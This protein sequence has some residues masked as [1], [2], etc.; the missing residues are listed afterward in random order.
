MTQ[1]TF[2][3]AI[4]KYYLPLNGYFTIVSKTYM[5]IVSRW[6]LFT[7]L[8]GVGLMCQTCYPIQSQPT[9]SPT[10]FP[11]RELRGAWI[12]TVHQIDWPSKQNFDSNKQKQEF[13]SILNQHQATG[14]NALFVQVRAASDAFYAVSDEPWSE[15]LTGEQGLP[16]SP[17]YDPL[18][19]QIEEAHNRQM[20]FHAWLNLN[21]GTHKT[22]TSVHP[23]NP[24]NRHPEWFYSYD[25]HLIYNFGLP[26]VRNHLL[27]IVRGIVQH[28]DVDGIHLDDYFY[29]YLVGNERIPD[30]KTFAKYGKGFKSIEE[31]RRSVVTGLIRDMA[32]T[33]QEVKPWVKFGVSPFGVWR[34]QQEDPAGSPTF[35]GQTSYDQL[36][37]D[38]LLWLKK[39]YIDYLAPQI[40]FSFE[41]GRVP[42][43]VLVDWWRAQ[44]HE[45]HL[46]VGH[47]TYKVR[48][49]KPEPGWD[50][51]NQIADQ[52]R[53]N[54]QFGNQIRGSIFFN[55]TSLLQNNLGVRDSIQQLYSVKALP[56]AYPWKGTFQPIPPKVIRLQ[57]KEEGIVLQW[58]PPVED[59]YRCYQWVIYKF[60]EGQVANIGNPEYI[61]AI[62]SGK[63]GQW[64]DRQ[65]YRVPGR[66]V[67]T[68]VDRLG[69]ESNPSKLIKSQA[70]TFVAT[71]EK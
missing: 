36:Y 31:W 38:G 42:Y 3:W 53:Y 20:E 26:E 46:F 71:E 5:N 58:K 12:A 16:P 52:I 4:Q 48:A 57:S 63:Q 66:Y 68:A 54:R 24:T 32:K 50:R 8:L 65:A 44:T 18:A 11:K 41:S 33:I 45:R 64:L 67:I 51:K 22:T 14:I 13:I 7:F 69:N 29:P 2:F 17:L 37:A 23:D 25:G 28:Y 49:D 1:G 40:Y 21:R 60:P 9:L 56:P 61:Q 15:W 30:E 27:K 6:A 35:A 39:G 47:A 43:A 55:T 10:R 59:T 34:N 70:G 19:F 62:V